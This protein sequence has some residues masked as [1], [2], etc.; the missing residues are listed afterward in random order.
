MVNLMKQF[1]LYKDQDFN[2]TYK[3]ILV[4]KQNEYN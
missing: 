4:N 3:N 1:T 2:C